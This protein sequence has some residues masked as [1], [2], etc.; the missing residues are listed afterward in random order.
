M[1]KRDLLKAGALFLLLSTPFSIHAQKKEKSPY[2]SYL[3]AFFSNNTPYGEQIRYAIS[4]D[5]F[6]YKALNE[7]R[8]FVASDSIA[9]KKGIR[10]PHIIR[11]EDGKTFYMVLTDMRSSE[12]WQ[13]NDGLVLMKS[14]DLLHWDHTAIH[15][16]PLCYT[17][18]KDVVKYII[19]I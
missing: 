1:K 10:D 17:L 18:L 15:F 12:G 4:E 9:R 16:P 11:A 3:F 6:N 5:G 19:N 13:S 8:P 2:D 7:G 14:T